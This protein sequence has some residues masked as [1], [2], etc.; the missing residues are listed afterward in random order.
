[1]TSVRCLFC[2]EAG[3]T[4]RPLIQCLQ[5]CLHDPGVFEPS[6]LGGVHDQRTGGHGHTG[7]G[8]IQQLYRS[9]GGLNDKRS[10]VH[11]A[12]MQAAEDQRGNGGQGLQRL[13][14]LVTRGLPVFGFHGSQFFL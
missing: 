13:G 2:W 11:G 10:E 7:Q 3:E 1:M 9:M 8:W 12:G 14:D 4:L 5:W 6:T